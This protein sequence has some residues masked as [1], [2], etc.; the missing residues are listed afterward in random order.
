MS[1]RMSKNLIVAVS[2]IGAL[3]LASALVAGYVN[4]EPIRPT[5]DTKLVGCGPGGCCSAAATCSEAT[6]SACSQSA[7]GGSACAM[8]ASKTNCAAATQG[9]C[10]ATQNPEPTGEPI[11]VC[12]KSNAQAKCCPAQC[13]AKC[14][15]ESCCALCT[16]EDCPND[17]PKSACGG[18]AGGCCPAAGACGA[19]K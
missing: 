3:V 12:P 10:T 8:D 16:C 17:C 5:N 1:M 18:L 14:C 15:P 13:P 9:S 4:S 11:A 19:A 2:I 7:A 6:D